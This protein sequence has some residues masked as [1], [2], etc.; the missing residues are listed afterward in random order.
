MDRTIYKIGKSKDT[1]ISEE[2]FKAEIEKGGGGY[3]A[4]PMSSREVLIIK[5]GVLKYR[6]YKE[7]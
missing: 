1:K 6:L 7:D 3:S 2:K 4:T 5:D